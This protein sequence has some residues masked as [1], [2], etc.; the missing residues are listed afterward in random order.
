M[1]LSQA[2]RCPGPTARLG[3]L[4]G[5]RAGARS[6][7][8]PIHTR[9]ATAGAGQA[10][11]LHVTGPITCNATRQ[12]LA[13]QSVAPRPAASPSPGSPLEMQDLRF[14]RDRM[15]ALWQF[16]EIPKWFR[17]TLAPEKH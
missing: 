16:T 10:R 12:A 5:G 8:I 11:P 3:H 7:S 9:R 2:V 13:I 6:R 14:L 15:D 4:E 17:G 1:R